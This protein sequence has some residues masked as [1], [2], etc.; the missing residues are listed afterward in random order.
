MDRQAAAAVGC[1][2]NSWLKPLIPLSTVMAASQVLEEQRTYDLLV[3][4]D[5]TARQS[6]ET[7]SNTLI[8]APTG[9]KV[10]IV[11]VAQVRVDQGP[12]TI[13]RE[14]VHLMTEEGVGFRDAIVQGS[15]ERLRPILMT[16]LVT[17][18]GLIPLALG[19]GEPG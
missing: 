5:D 13:N 3:R 8:D 10:L 7:I 12:N 2:Q 16:A 1:P 19:V 4:F 6:V 14:N 11:Q 17:G 18:V 9:V 15:M